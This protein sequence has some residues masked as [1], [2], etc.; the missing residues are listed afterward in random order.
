MSYI[1]RNLLPDEKILFRTKK[2]LIIFFFPMVLAIFSIYATNYMHHNF[3][4]TKVEF[5][6]W[7]VTLIIWCYVGLEYLTSEYA[8]TNKRVMMREG[9]FNR[10]ANEVRLATISQ[11]N[12]DQSLLGQLLNY[13]IVSIN[14]FGAYDSY[15]TIDH[16][17]EFQKYVNQQLDTLVK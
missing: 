8:V 17:F 3:I 6:P 13:G 9:F 5:A 15:P 4:L 16:P 2:H 10:H 12:V 7:V 11:V 14:A 1:D